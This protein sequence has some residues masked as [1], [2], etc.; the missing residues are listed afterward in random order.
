MSN[1][2]LPVALLAQWNTVQMT[3]I[4]GRHHCG[5]QRL[6]TQRLTACIHVC[7]P[8]VAESRLRHRDRGFRSLACV[9]LSDFVLPM[10]GIFPSREPSSES[11][12]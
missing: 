8:H 1:V 11:L 2:S 6:S 4:S 5:A 10:S 12:P 9:R 3:R 7:A